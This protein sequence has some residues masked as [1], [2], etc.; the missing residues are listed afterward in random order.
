MT[1]LLALDQGTS[2]SRS[3]VFDETGAIVAVAQ[4]E[5][6]QLFPQPGWIEHDPMEI[7]HSQLA[8]CREVLAKTGLKADAL[9]ALGITNQRETTVLWDRATGEPVYN[10]IVWQDRRTEALCEDLRARGLAGA[11]H[12]KTGLVLDPYFSGTK[13]RWI[14]DAVPGA[15]A[16]AMRGELAFGTID[17]WLAWKMTGG[18]LHV[19]DVTNASRTMLWNLHE[20]CWDA[21]LLDW[22]G[23]PASLLPSV[24]PSSHVYG[25]TDTEV[26]GSPVIIGGIAGDQ[27]AALFG[28][29]CFTPGMAKN[30]YGTGCFLLLNTG[31]QCAQ[32]QH[33]LIST[34]A[35][36][37][38][39]QPAYALEGSVF[40][41]GAVVQW[42]RDGLGAIGHAGEAE[43]LA[44]SVPDSGGVV[45]VPSFTGLG[46][47][48]WVPSA[49]G[50]I[51][52]LSRGSTV[53]HIARAA[54][55]AIAFQSAALL[56]AMTRDA[57]APITELRVDGGACANNLLLQFQADLLGIPVV[58][59]Q[60]IE[61][62][63]L[64]AAYL[65]GLAIG[66]YRGVEELAS[67]WRADRTFLPTIGRDQAASLM[68]QW[69][70]A[71]RRFAGNGEG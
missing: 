21:Q 31:E 46:A 20:G 30:T 69:E 67:H 60:V 13:L 33:G 43:G 34:A 65:A 52:G 28:Q 1:Y 29:T 63:A 51:L 2:S 70:V 25:E 35:C 58:R 9:G 47:P 59:P 68:Q 27:Q 45:F 54:L 4:R 64:G 42:L 36:Q 15:R 57:Q 23:I 17:T 39:A 62:T 32:S 5:F 16:R 11:I 56:D 24:H 48:Y 18:R 50:A 66:Q 44:A 49:K 40:I 12:A 71:V 26:L 53:G 7:W 3:M 41:G 61:T 6:R 22:L 19:S 8:T 37:V 14:L 38:S 10:A 55:E